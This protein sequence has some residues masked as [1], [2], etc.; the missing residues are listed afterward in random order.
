MRLLAHLRVPGPQNSWC[1]HALCCAA[2]LHHSCNKHADGA[3]VV[4]CAVP[5]LA[6]QGLKQLLLAFVGATHGRPCQ[7]GLHPADCRPSRGGGRTL[8][9]C[10]VNT[11][12]A[13]PIMGDGSNTG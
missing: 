3:I 8:R 5:V 7:R 11:D 2:Q 10:D 13:Y 4:F 6:L 12:Y 9:C 1:M